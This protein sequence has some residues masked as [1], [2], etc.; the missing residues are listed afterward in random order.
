[1]KTV[2]EIAQFVDGV[3]EGDADVQITGLAGLR[4]AQPGDL[5]LLV[6]AK[7]AAMLAQTQAAA[8]LVKSDWEGRSPCPVIR[9]K[10]PN[11]A[12]TM[13]ALELSPD[14]P[15]L[16][17][18]VHPSAVLA[19]DVQIGDGACIGPLCVLEAGVSVGK[20]AVLVA[21]CYLGAGASVGEQSVLHAHVSVR[22]G[23]T[24]GARTIVH[25]G[26][27]IGSDGFGYEPQAD[28]RWVKI[29][30]VGIVEVGDD[31]EIGAN[32]T[33]DR[34]RFGR[35]I[36]K[37]GA[38]IDNLVQ[39]AHNVVVGE[40]TAMAAHVGIAGSTVIGR[41]VQMGGKASSA[42]HLT[43]GDGAIMGGN[44]G[45]VVDL[46][47]GSISMGYVARPHMAWKRIRSAEERLPELLRRVKKLEK[48][49][50]ALEQKDR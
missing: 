15:A 16:E 11:V 5:S 14:T 34:A 20:D 27:V 38:K 4:E 13:L 42:G 32:T 39:I 24:I 23:C 17:P 40:N 45:A 33:I 3:V 1:M 10:D 19:A 29:P 25:D 48:T 46:E 31:V 28:G 36:I 6:S 43:I 35:T 8:V 44:C 18:G 30:Q 37:N 26:A 21:S 22:E 9:V 47:P 2:A 49:L 12:M 41:N 7:Y 50:E